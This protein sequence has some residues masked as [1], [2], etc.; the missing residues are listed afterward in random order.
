[1]LRKLSLYSPLLQRSVTVNT[2]NLC[3]RVTNSMLDRWLQYWPIARNTSNC[4]SNISYTWCFLA[5]NTMYWFLQNRFPTLSVSTATICLYSVHCTV[6]SVQSKRGA[7]QENNTVTCLYY[8][9]TC[10]K[11]W[12]TNIA[13]FWIALTCL[14]VDKLHINWCSFI[15][16]R[17]KL[18]WT[19]LLSVLQSTPEWYSSSM[20]VHMWT[21][22]HYIKSSPMI[23]SYIQFLITS[24]NK[25]HK[26][27]PMFR[28]CYNS[29]TVIFAILQAQVSH[30]ILNIQQP[31]TDI[32]TQWLQ[33]WR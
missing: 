20:L 32:K 14:L 8:T 17:F 2:A 13:R 23:C 25:L 7:V 33:P 15:V 26:A 5:V 16:I 30:N 12:I 21:A 9:I 22:F 10:C 18:F 3:L 27:K 29:D 6:C 11:V 4:W 31:I 1:M 28:H 19:Q 24:I